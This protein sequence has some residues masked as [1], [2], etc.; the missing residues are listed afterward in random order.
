MTV[1]DMVSYDWPCRHVHGRQERGGAAI[2]SAG[3]W[4]FL[5]PHG[6]VLNNPD[7]RHRASD[8]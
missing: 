3:W 5:L 7:H 6:W 8:A 4:V 1:N 2:R